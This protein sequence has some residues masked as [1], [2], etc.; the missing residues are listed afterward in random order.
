[1]V[2]PKGGKREVPYF[3]CHGYFK[4]GSLAHWRSTD[5]CVKSWKADGYKKSEDLTPEERSRLNPELRKRE[6]EVEKENKRCFLS[7]SEIVNFHE[8]RC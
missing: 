8:L 1:M 2:H 7:Y 6:S 5:D 3:T 4:A